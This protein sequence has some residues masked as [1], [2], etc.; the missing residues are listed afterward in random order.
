MRPVIT[1]AALALAA[2]ALLAPSAVAAPRFERIP[3]FHAPGTPSKYNRVGILEVGPRTAKN[4]LVLNPGT[5]AS[6]A[7]FAPLART[8]VA[9]A[10]GWQVWAVERRENLLEDHSMLDRAKAGT[11]TG[12]E[13]FDYYLGFTTDSSV[14]THFQFIPD[15]QVGFARKWGMRVEIEDLRRVVLRAQKFARRV[16]VGG[17]SLGGSIT[18]AYATWDFGGRPGAGGLSGLVFI[19]G[20]SGPAPVTAA[21]AT[22]SLQ[23]LAQS[24]PW[25]TFGGITAPFAGLFNVVGCGLAKVEPNAPSRL[26]AWPGLPANLNAPVRVSNEAGYGY[27][28]DTKTSPPGLVAA[29]AHL[30]HLAASGDP[31]GWDGAGELTP[32]QRYADMF[33]GWGLKGLDGTAWYH[34]RRLTIDSGAVA[35]GNANPAQRVLD[36][37]ATHGH[38]L[39]KSLRLYAFGAALGGQRVLDATKTLAVQSGIPK[40]QLTLV[41]RHTTYA[42]NDPNSAVPANDFVRF[43]LPFLNRVAR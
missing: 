27:A 43:L 40:G 23:D 3:G 9:K 7:Y 25:L 42:H 39:P 4:V 11:A 31:R 41:D 17:H 6:A 2:L 14:Q 21:Q 20:G 36:V 12:K 28:L 16:V 1:T 10:K 13:L 24:S 5:S 15:A 33:C 8:I 35:D 19:D 34:P 30:G 37:R 26:Q 32:V 38:N 29:Q 22:K 18:T